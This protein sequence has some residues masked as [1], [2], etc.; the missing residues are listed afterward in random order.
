MILSFE[1]GGHVIRSATQGNGAPNGRHS[2]ILFRG[3][4]IQHFTVYT[5]LSL[6]RTQISMFLKKIL[7]IFNLSYLM[8]SLVYLVADEQRKVSKTCTRH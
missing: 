4:T 6:V 1:T 7:I 3:T 8:L 5:G 2:P